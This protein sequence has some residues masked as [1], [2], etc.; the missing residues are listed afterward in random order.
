M[1]SYLVPTDTD[2]RVNGFQTL[3]PGSSQKVDFTGTSAQS[4]QF[5]IKTSLVALY[6]TEDCFIKIGTDP[7]ATTDGTSMFIPGGIL[8]GIGLFT[9][10]NEE[11]VT[12]MA[13]IQASSSGTLYITEAA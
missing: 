7:V 11:T 12:K 10:Y 6:A 8:L 1:P 13:V 3:T 4:T 2:Y 5:Y 9:T